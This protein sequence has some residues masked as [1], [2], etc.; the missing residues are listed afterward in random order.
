MSNAVTFSVASCAF[1]PPRLFVD[2]AE[3]SSSLVRVD[4]FVFGS[5]QSLP[6]DPPL[7]TVREIARIR[8]LKNLG[9]P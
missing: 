3:T 1:T 5:M 6:V 9:R 4:R 8:L 2:P 7:T